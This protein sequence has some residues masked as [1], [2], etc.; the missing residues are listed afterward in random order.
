LQT[1]TLNLQT[2][3]SSQVAYLKLVTNRQPASLQKMHAGGDL[4]AIERYI[5]E[6]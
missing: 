1:K 6:N 4:P 5:K 3:I 2:W